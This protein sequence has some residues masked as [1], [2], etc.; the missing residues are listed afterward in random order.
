MHYGIL[1]GRRAWDKDRTTI[2]LS[3]AYPY[4]FAFLILT[5]A[6]SLIHADRSQAINLGILVISAAHSVAAKS[7][8]A[9]LIQF[10]VV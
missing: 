4:P 2:C 7:D 8:Q 3:Y 6:V 1:Q 10:M 9:S 5:C